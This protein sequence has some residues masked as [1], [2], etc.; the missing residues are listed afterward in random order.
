M[1]RAANGISP[2]PCN[3]ISALGRIRSSTGRPPPSNA[4]DVEPDASHEDLSMDLSA[5]CLKILVRPERLELP[6]Y[7]F[8]ASRSIQL[9]YGRPFRSLSKQPKPV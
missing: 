3:L 7:W 1:T 9:S 5:K 6:T 4:P 8:E 2:T